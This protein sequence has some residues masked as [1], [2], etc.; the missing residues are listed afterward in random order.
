M[1]ESQPQHHTARPEPHLVRWGYLRISE[2]GH[3]EALSFLF[4]LPP[5]QSPSTLSTYSPPPPPSTYWLS[6]PLQ[7]P[8]RIVTLKTNML[9]RLP[10]FLLPGVLSPEVLARDQIHQDL[11]F[12]QPRSTPLQ[13]NVN[14]SSRGSTDTAP[15]PERKMI[16]LY[17]FTVLTP[18]SLF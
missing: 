5:I 7:L 14:N 18:S 9:P 1:A 17:L 11:A 6:A 13:L 15:S 8:T 12:P 3:R 16:E 4:S 10:K 2:P